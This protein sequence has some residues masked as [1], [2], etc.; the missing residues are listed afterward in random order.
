[1]DSI[2]Q[3][4]SPTG[5]FTLRQATAR[6]LNTLSAFYKSRI[7]VHHHLDWR[8]S[9][10]WLGYQPYYVL[11]RRGEII[12]ALATPIDPEGISWVRVFGCA[13][14][15]PPERMLPILLDQ[16]RKDLSSQP[17]PV[18]AALGLQEWFREVLEK[19]NFELKQHIVVLQW[20]Y[21]QRPARPTP[22]NLMIRQMTT[23]DLP[24]VAHVDK[25]AF[26]PLWQNSLDALILAFHKA[27]IATVATLDGEI[28]GY[29]IST[30]TP[31]NTHLARLAVKPESQR[32]N[33]GFELVRDMLTTSVK[34]NSWQVS[35]NTQSDNESSLTLY[36]SLGFVR[37]GENFP[38]YVYQNREREIE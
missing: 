8:S 4:S 6:D 5:K 16:C 22:E 23:A 2:A 9:I 33:I 18:I 32:K 14:E 28:V 15:L 37:T 25:L 27:S 20:D 7:N 1:V 11:T 26:K 36:K 34:L 29:Q 21:H 38:V 13:M 10:E 31:I 17:Q 30:S 35:V 3:P 12:A 19:N 24:S